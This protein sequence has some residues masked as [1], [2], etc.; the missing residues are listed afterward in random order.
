MMMSV[1]LYSF[2]VLMSWKNPVIVVSAFTTSTT[3][4]LGLKVAVPT[5]P[6]YYYHHDVEFCR[7]LLSPSYYYDNNGKCHT[8]LK[9]HSSPTSS[10]LSSST[11]ENESL[12]NYTVF[13]T[14]NLQQ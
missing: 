7:R 4:K 2:S 1:F 9:R 11:S 6:V 3:T 14:A 5:R 10:S 13:Q 8:F 12:A